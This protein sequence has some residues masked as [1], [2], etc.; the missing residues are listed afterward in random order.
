MLTTDQRELQGM[1]Q[2]RGSPVQDML[3]RVYAECR[4]QLVTMRDVDAMRMLQGRAQLCREMLDAIEK[5]FSTNGK[6]P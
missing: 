4:D 3:A 2:L 5:G 1:Q 6:R